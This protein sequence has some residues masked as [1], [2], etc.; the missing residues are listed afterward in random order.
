MNAQGLDNIDEPSKSTYMS[1][2]HILAMIS[3]IL[4]VK[5]SFLLHIIKIDPRIDLW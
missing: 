2:G 5:G 4:Y 3:T 1:V